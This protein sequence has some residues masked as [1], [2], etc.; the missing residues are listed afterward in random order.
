[1]NTYISHGKVEEI[2]FTTELNTVKTL[3]KQQQW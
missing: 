1:M 3:N 2:G